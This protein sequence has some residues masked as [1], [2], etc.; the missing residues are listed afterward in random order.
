MGRSYYQRTLQIVSI[1]IVLAARRYLSASTA[2]TTILGTGSG[3]DSWIFRGQDSTARPMVPMEGTKRAAVV[4]WPDGDWTQS[5]RHNTMGFPTLSVDVYI[6][7]GRDLASNVTQPNL[8]PRFQ[9]IWEVL[10]SLLH[11]PSH[12]DLQ[13]D[14]LRVLTSHKIAGHKIYPFT[15]TD[16]VRFS[17]SKFAI[18]L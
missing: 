2:L 13:W 9:E 7:P 15:D 11:V 17:R 10:D 6:D 18:T 3:F 4:L 16:G 14:S 5:N 12:T 1:D 8:L